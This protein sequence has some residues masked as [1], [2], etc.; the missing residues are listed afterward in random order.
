ML[1]PIWR[2]KHQ[3]QPFQ[4]SHLYVFNFS[5]APTQPDIITP[6]R[7][8]TS[9]YNPKLECRARRDPWCFTDDRRRV[10]RHCHSKTWP[11]ISATVKRGDRTTFYEVACVTLCSINL[12]QP[13]HITPHSPLAHDLSMLTVPKNSSTGN[14]RTILYHTSF[15]EILSLSAFPSSSASS[16]MILALSPCDTKFLA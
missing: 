4:S 11:C 1:L 10:P 7:R 9:Y 13:H 5:R 16:R 12:P 3:N 15:E 2:P 8:L 14:P 6:R